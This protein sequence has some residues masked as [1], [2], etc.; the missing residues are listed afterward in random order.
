VSRVLTWILGEGGLLGSRIRRHFALEAPQGDCWPPVSPR[1]PWNQP[2]LLRERLAREL[3]DFFP[4]ARERFDAWSIFWCAGAGVIRTP[5]ADLVAETRLFEWFLEELARRQRA[6]GR[7]IPGQ[8]ALASSAG[9]VYGEPRGTLLDEDSPCLPLSEYGRQKLLQE[10]ALSR[11][12]E[13]ES[14]LGCLV[15]RLTTLYGPGQD[16]SKAQGFI[17]QLVRSLL[18]RRPLRVYVPLDTQRDFLFVDDAARAFLRCSS[19][20]LS[21][22]TAGRSTKIFASGRSVTLAEVAATLRLLSRQR[23]R[24]LGTS[25]GPNAAAHPAKLRYRSAALTA[26]ELPPTTPLIQG[27]HA[28]LQEQLALLKQGR[29]S[30]PQL[31]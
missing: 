29:L 13:S 15:G 28:I 30:A 5:D 23:V 11:W 26:V 18:F 1:L 20:L 10:H 22:G 9:A 19:W 3:D 24:I 12:A 2:D 8:L 7:R 14:D 27:M 16:L 21:S 25:S 31:A 6:P 17:S 4:A